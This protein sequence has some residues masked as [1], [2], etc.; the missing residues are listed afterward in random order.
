MAI[1]IAEL[2]HYALNLT[3]VLAG[4]QTA[5]G[6][7]GAWRRDYHL[8]KLSHLILPWQI[9][10]LSGAAAALIY[11]FVVSDFSVSLVISNSHSLQPLLYR[12]AASWGNHEGSLLLWCLVLSF[13]A[14]LAGWFGKNLPP[15]LLARVIGVQALIIFGFLGF[16]LYTS[17]PFQRI[18]PP[19]V[20]GR[21]LNPLL[22]DPG[23]AFHPPMLYLGYVGLSL[24][25][26][27]AIAGLLEGKVDQNWA[28]WIRPWTLLAWSFLSLGIGLG[29]RW[30]YYELGWGGFWFW[31]PVENASLMPWL[32]ATAL[33]H[34]AIV[35]EKRNT[36]KGWTILLSIMAFGL[37][38]IG[39]F[40]VRSGV[41]TSVH[42]FA[43]DPTRGLYILFLLMA[44]MGGGLTIYAW[45]AHLFRGRI[46]FSL[47]SREGALLL[48]NWLLISGLATIV[49]GTLYP[50]FLDAVGGDKI[51]VGPPYYYLSFIPLMIPLL[52]L[53]PLGPLLSWRQAHWHKLR[54]LAWP[55]LVVAFFIACLGAWAYREQAFAAA[56]I[57]A[58]GGWIIATSG[59]SL[60]RQA[61]PVSSIP[62]KVALLRLRHL[63]LAHWGVAFAH[64]G[65]GLVVLGAASV[66]ILGQ[67]LIVATPL[68]QP[69]NLGAY[70]IT[71]TKL[72]DVEGPNYTAWRATIA[73]R[74][75]GEAKPM[76]ILEPEKRRYQSATQME[77]TEAAIA[78]QIGQDI[79]IAVAPPPPTDTNPDK[80][81]L[82]LRA[83]I[84]PMAFWLWLGFGA[85]AFG[86]LLSLADRRLR[87]APIERS[88]PIQAQI[89]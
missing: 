36:M 62:F 16:L 57:F 9:I 77:T 63:P 75:K 61:R 22:Q 69:H 35:T 87:I 31:D 53:M 45:R 24:V 71:A 49:T 83:Y 8:I 3:F 32:A 68:N 4:L 50:V 28:R 40:I 15:T 38:M 7:I 41:V 47:F 66:T 30:A 70:E 27:F 10:L 88:R 64:G 39:T 74:K 21:A 44:L 48:N 54:A 12:V 65:L 20:E 84:K 86:G 73:L 13:F 56:L 51:S 5:S 11:S 80:P 46:I 26:S 42:A 52:L 2:G 82:I 85:I 58:L 6:L 72:A 59:L 76:L 25:F 60:W 34:S 19:A 81:S 33:L 29:S 79:Y 23:L 37:S 78:T 43:S 55:M 67:E 14:G 1:S 18:M 89:S 17:N